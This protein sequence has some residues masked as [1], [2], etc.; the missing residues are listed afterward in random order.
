MQIMSAAGEFGFD[1]ESI[2]V[3]GDDLILIGKMG[4]WEATTH[5]SK[6]DLI[7]LLRLMLTNFRIW[8]YLLRLPLALVRRK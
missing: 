2:G 5:V 6:S 3:E 4:V 1:I 8:A 7:K